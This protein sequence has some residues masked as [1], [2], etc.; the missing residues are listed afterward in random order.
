MFNI[1]ILID[2]TI[3]VKDNNIQ[4]I[5]ALCHSIDKNK[6]KLVIIGYNNFLSNIMAKSFYLS[7]GEVEY[8]L[9]DNNCKTLPHCKIIYCENEMQAYGIWHTKVNIFVF[10]WGIN[11]KL[12]LSLYPKNKKKYYILDMI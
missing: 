2:H 8:I 9:F 3:N 12:P 11:N 1:G 7:G 6:Y 5:S 10:L 4:L